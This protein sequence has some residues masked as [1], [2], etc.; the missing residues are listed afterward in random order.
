MASNGSIFLYI[1]GGWTLWV[2]GHTPAPGENGPVH[3]LNFVSP[4][5]LSR[6]F[7]LF[8]MPI[9][10]VNDSRAAAMIPGGKTPEEVVAAVEE[11]RRVCANDQSILIGRCYDPNKPPPRHQQPQYSNASGVGGDAFAMSQTSSQNVAGANPNQ[12]LFLQLLQQQQCGAMSSQVSPLRQPPPMAFNHGA[13]MGGVTAGAFVGNMMNGAGM[14]SAAPQLGFGSGNYFNPMMPIGRG[15]G[16]MPAPN[17]YGAAPSRRAAPPMMGGRG[18]GRGFPSHSPFQAPARDQPEP[19]PDLPPIPPEILEIYMNPQQKLM[20][21]TMPGARITAWLREHEIPTE[22]KNPRYVFCKGGIVLMLKT[23]GEEVANSKPVELFDQQLCAH[24]LIHNYCSRSNCL[25]RHHTEVQLRQL[26]AAKHVE[27]RSMTKKERHRLSEEVLAKEREGRARADEERDQRK[28]RMEGKRRREGGVGSGDAVHSAPVAAAGISGGVLS[29]TGFSRP[30]LS[31]VDVGSS[32]EEKDSDKKSKESRDEQLTNEERGGSHEE[33]QS[34]QQQRQ[35]VQKSVASRRGGPIPSR[36]VVN[37]AD[38]GVTD[39]DSDSDS[40]S[41]GENSST[42]SSSASPSEPAVSDT[43][44]KATDAK[45]GT[46]KDTDGE[47]KVKECVEPTAEAEKEA[48]ME[49]TAEAEKEALMEPTAEAEKEALMEPTAE[50]EKEALMEPT[51]EAE[52]GASMGQETSHQLELIEKNTGEG[53]GTEAKLPPQDEGE[54]KQQTT[55]TAEASEKPGE[56]QA[57]GAI[58]PEDPVDDDDSKKKRKTKKKGP[59]AKRPHSGGAKTSSAKA[60]QSKK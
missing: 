19:L 28:E 27:L 16:L 31:H 30:P 56:E 26:I 37:P 41:D 38:I 4:R 52:E 43:A 57:Q 15:A 44:K 5:E 13:M 14:M 59:V 40:D 34:K 2:P 48:L 18:G 3:I 29:S 49:P 36:R 11:L 23:V 12:A 51:A 53:G 50:A 39:S 9:Q 1:T 22:T 47:V 20:C 46:P 60:K 45:I 55:M 6:S 35:V 32:D 10:L 21:S 54:N 24:F 25:H 7:Y 8:D 42:S 33:K 58:A 17:A